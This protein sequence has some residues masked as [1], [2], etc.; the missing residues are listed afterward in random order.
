MW[1]S[2]SSSA[3]SHLSDLSLGF[4]LGLPPSPVT[5]RSCGSSSKM[6]L[7]LLLPLLW[8]GSQAQH[9]RF[10]LQVQGSATV[11]E[12]LCVRVPCTIFYPQVNDSNTDPVYGYWF[13]EGA[14]PHQEAP[15]ATNNPDRE[16]QEET[17]G[18]FHLLGNPQIY[19]CSLDIKDT[20]RSDSGTYFFRVER[21]SFL[22]YNYRQNQLSVHVTALT[23]TP[24]IYIQETLE[25]GHPKNITC[26][27]PWACERGTPP[28]FS[29][30]GVALTSMGSKTPH[31]SVLTLTPEPQDHGTNLTCQVTFPGAGVSTERTVQLNVSFPAGRSRPMTEVVLVAIGEAA[32]KILLLLLCLIF[33]IMR[34]YRRKVMRPA[35]GM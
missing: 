32:V 33:L 8:A 28:T 10:W 34:S 9:G 21:G 14:S 3:V 11:Q 35:G 16:V 30:M 31:S 19:D 18:R 6:P 23:E 15:V 20:R 25:A 24:D 5:P 1:V 27:V 13:R 7:L 4:L 17:Q 2:S 22:R 12:G 29:W 26:T